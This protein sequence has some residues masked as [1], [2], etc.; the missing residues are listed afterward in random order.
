MEVVK[1][2]FY[3]PD[4]AVLLMISTHFTLGKAGARS[5][6]SLGRVFVINNKSTWPKNGFFQ[7]H[8]SLSLILHMINRQNVLLSCMFL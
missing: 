2:L 1:R 6:K 7:E 4:T 5:A 8:P 3:L